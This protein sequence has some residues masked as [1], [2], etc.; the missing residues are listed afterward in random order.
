MALTCCSEDHER[1][2]CS[3][4]LTSHHYISPVAIL[5]NIRYL[6]HENGPKRLHNQA[7]ANNGMSDIDSTLEDMRDIADNAEVTNRAARA[8]SVNDEGFQHSSQVDGDVRSGQAPHDYRGAKHGIID[9]VGSPPEDKDPHTS[10]KRDAENA[11][12]NHY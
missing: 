5:R 12:L 10:K 1:Q 8:I 11:C 6:S 4:N 7:V 3:R 2:K 9:L